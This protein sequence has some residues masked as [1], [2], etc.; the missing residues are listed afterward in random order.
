MEKSHFK[1]TLQR[2]EKVIKTMLIKAQSIKV[3]FHRA[4]GLAASHFHVILTA[5]C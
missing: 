5:L 4:F 2:H 1:N 3:S